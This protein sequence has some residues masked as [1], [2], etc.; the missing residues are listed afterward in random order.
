MPPPPHFGTNLFPPRVERWTLPLHSLRE[1]PPGLGWS[2]ESSVYP[3]WWWA[4]LFS[5]VWRSQWIE[6]A[7]RGGQH[8][9]PGG[10]EWRVRLQTDGGAVSP[11]SIT[12]HHD[13]FYRYLLFNWHDITNAIW[14]YLLD[15]FRSFY[16][17]SWDIM[18]WIL[19]LELGSL[20]EELV[21]SPLELAV[22][23]ADCAE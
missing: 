10:K 7:S 8:L 9:L 14:W 16:T 6:L 3:G 4:E 11:T 1:W 18:I 19:P 13:I 15:L 22:E 12:L 23:K 20:L 21:V 2:L 17:D 5:L